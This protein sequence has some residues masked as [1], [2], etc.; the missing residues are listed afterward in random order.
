MKLTRSKLRKLII[1]QLLFENNSPPKYLPEKR[2][3]ELFNALHG[4]FAGLGTDENRIKKIFTEFESKYYILDLYYAYSELLEEIVKD[5]TV[6]KM[7]PGVGFVDRLTSL[8]NLISKFAETDDLSGDLITHLQ[9]DG[10]LAQAE[11]LEVALQEAEKNGF[12]RKIIE[13]DYDK[14][15]RGTPLP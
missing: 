14:I 10:M 4:G 1:E 12:E 13:F 11:Q 2:A 9:G 5:L 8:Q 3:K 15:S 7:T 6:G